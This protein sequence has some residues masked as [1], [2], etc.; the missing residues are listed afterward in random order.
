MAYQCQHYAS[1]RADWLIAAMLFLMITIVER[2]GRK[3]NEFPNKC[4]YFAS[5]RRA[6]SS[7]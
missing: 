7:A 2:Y 6:S 4:Y 3:D 5:I 1:L